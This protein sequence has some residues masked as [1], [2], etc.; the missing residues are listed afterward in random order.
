MEIPSKY[1]SFILVERPNKEILGSKH[2]ELRELDMPQVEAGGALVKITYLSFDAS[3]QV[4]AIGGS[5]Y[6]SQVKK[7]YETKKNLS[8]KNHDSKGTQ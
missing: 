7:K 4:M 8:I 6:F 3:Q 1:K 2:L 5:N